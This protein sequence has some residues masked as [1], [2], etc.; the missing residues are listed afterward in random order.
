MVAVGCRQALHIK[1][2][3]TVPGI[4]RVHLGLAC[5]LPRELEAC[6]LEK[7]IC[8]KFKDLEEALECE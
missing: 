3:D 1:V 2:L 8:S 6:L 4:E 7:K 5:E